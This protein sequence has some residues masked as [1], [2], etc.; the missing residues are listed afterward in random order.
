MQ[1]E[2]GRFFVDSFGNQSTSTDDIRGDGCIAYSMGEECAAKSCASG[3]E[4]SGE[5]AKE[6]Y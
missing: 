1:V 2:P 3:G 4:I 6:Y 5:P